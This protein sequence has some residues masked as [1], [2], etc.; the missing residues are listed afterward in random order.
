[1]SAIGSG[2][3]WPEIA[4]GLGVVA[5][6]LVVI[7]DTMLAPAAPAYAQ[8]G[9]T[10]FPY[11]GGAA[12]LVLGALLM[13]EG[14]RGGWRDPA[15]E[16]ERGRPN[17]PGLLWVAAG[18]LVNVAL[19]GFLGFVLASAILFACVARGFDSRRPLRDL[20]I[21]FALAFV[22]YVGFAKLLSIKLG[23]GLIER[24]L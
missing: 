13:I 18:L 6:G 20:G 12:L 7:G 9:P 22:S 1:M 24:F 2:P 16:A 8:V 15:S 23:E 17:F 19:I 5:L 10:A 4:I 14:G 21:G 3:A 11:G